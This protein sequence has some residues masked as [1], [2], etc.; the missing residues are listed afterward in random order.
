MTSAAGSNK[1]SRP[2]NR[3]SDLQLLIFPTALGIWLVLTVGAV[4]VLNV[5]TLALMALGWATLA[6]VTTLSVIAP[7]RFA[8]W[9]LAFLGVVVFGG[10]ALLID[11]FSL[12]TALN[13]LMFATGLLG[14]VVLGNIIVRQIGGLAT[15]IDINRRLI[16]ELQIRDDSGL[17]KWQYAREGLKTEVARARRWSRNLSLILLR[18][19]NW[20]FIVD[21]H[22]TSGANKVLD[23]VS[24]VAGEVLRMVDTV[25]RYDNVTFGAILPETLDDG[26]RHAAQRVIDAVAE[27]TGARLY[28]GIATFPGSALTDDNLVTATENALQMAVALDRQIVSSNEQLDQ[29]QGAPNEPTIDRYEEFGF[30]SEVAVQSQPLPGSSKADQPP[31][32]RRSSGQPASTPGDTMDPSFYGWQEIGT[33][34]ER[35]LEEAVAAALSAPMPQPDIDA[36]EGADATA[37]VTEAAPEPPPADEAPAVKP[38][39]TTDVQWSTPEHPAEARSAAPVDWATDEAYSVDNAIIGADQPSAFRTWRGDQP[40]TPADRLPQTDQMFNSSPAAKPA[41]ASTSAASPMA[42]MPKSPTAPL[43]SVT[44]TF[45][46]EGNQ[47][48]LPVSTAV[49]APIRLRS[50]YVV[51]Q[52]GT[53]S[54]LPATTRQV[55]D[56]MHL[57]L[58]VLAALYD[59]DQ[60]VVLT[61][62]GPAANSF[63]AVLDTFDERMVSFANARV[64]ENLALPRFAFWMKFVM[65]PMSSEVGETTMVPTLILPDT[66]TEQDLRQAYTGRKALNR[67]QQWHHDAEE[68]AQAWERMRV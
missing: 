50:R 14:I 61:F 32:E 18:V 30:P 57:Q 58:Q 43:G 48:V 21:K 7:F 11:G 22:G 17:V 55:T 37:P 63:E 19:V 26:A 40:G 24:H 36:P 8:G 65:A 12:A 47:R 1:N 68:W 5:D 51:T 3:R 16:D 20:D 62:K 66:L 46:D 56:N 6:V 2:S 4:T 59:N 31:V 29:V 33:D 53:T 49:I 45:W 10:A 9:M 25:T 34:E 67:F 52:H 15:Q 64:P 44:M 54:Y 35:E 39:S 41:S 27:R 60:P 42:P 23:D 28:A 13:I 38:L